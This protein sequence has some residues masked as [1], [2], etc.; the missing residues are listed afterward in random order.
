MWESVVPT[1]RFQPVPPVALLG[2][3]SWNTV[4]P[5]RDRS[6]DQRARLP[7]PTPAAP[8]TSSHALLGKHL[9]GASLS[10][11]GRRSGSGYVARTLQRLHDSLP[12]PNRRR[13]SRSPTAATIAGRCPPTVCRRCA[14]RSSCP[15]GH[16]EEQGRLPKRAVGVCLLGG[17]PLRIHTLGDTLRAASVS[18]RLASLAR[19][20]ALKPKLDPR[21]PHEPTGGLPGWDPH[22]TAP[23]EVKS[24]SSIAYPKAMHRLPLGLDHLAPLSAARERRLPEGG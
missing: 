10:T 7:I 24:G 3:P 21:R 17:L 9:A 19:S 18:A 6:L 20:S 22:F 12:F 14:P 2:F 5:S 11:R 16:V 8:T 4:L 23:R 13:G 15:P 1:D